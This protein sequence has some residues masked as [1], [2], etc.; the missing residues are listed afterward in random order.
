ML[1]HICFITL[2]YKSHKTPV[3]YGLTPVAKTPIVKR[4]SS[5][6]RKHLFFNFKTGAVIDKIPAS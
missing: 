6:I 3:A 1:F 2:Q 5:K 4:M